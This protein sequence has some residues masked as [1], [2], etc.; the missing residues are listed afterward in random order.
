MTKVLSES[1][2][3]WEKCLDY[4]RDEL[5][6]PAQKYHTWIHPLQAEIDGQHLNLLAPNQFVLDWV[7]NHFLEQIQTTV[8]AICEANPLTV[9][10]SIGT[11]KEAEPKDSRPLPQVSTS[12]IPQKSQVSFGKSNDNSSNESNL[13]PLF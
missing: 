12:Q 9:R 4:L 5:Q 3:L 8:S 7:Q 10:L 13:N 11:K 1:A 6:M 2:E